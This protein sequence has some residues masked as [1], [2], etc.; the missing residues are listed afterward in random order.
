MSKEK[1]DYKKRIKKFLTFK[2]VLITSVALLFLV[3]Y[4]QIQSVVGTFSFLQGRDSSL[5]TEIGELKESYVSFGEDL[6]EIR[7]FLR[8]PTKNYFDVEEAESEEGKNEEELQIAMFQ[9]VT[10]LSN[11]E[12]LTKKLNDGKIYLTSLVDSIQF[13]GFIMDRELYMSGLSDNES[14]SFISINDLDGVSLV[15]IS[16]DKENGNIYLN[17]FNESQLISASS[18][19]DFESQ[20]K[21]F[22]DD[23]KE[24]LISE[25]KEISKKKQ[26]ILSAITSETTANSLL[27]LGISIANEPVLTSTNYVYSIYNSS[28]EVIGEIVFDTTSLDITLLDKQDESVSVKATDISTALIPFLE[29]LDTRSFLQKKTD[30]ALDKLNKT[31]S[32]KGFKLLLSQAEL[33]ISEEPRETDDRFYFD[34]YNSSE[35]HLSS[36]V[37][38]KAT[39]VVNIVNPDGTNSQNIFFFDSGSKKKTLQLPDVIPDYGDESFSLDNSFNILLAGKHGS[40]VDTMIFAHINEDTRKIRMVSIPRDLYYNGRKIN[41]FAHFYGMPELKK[42]L[43]DITGYEL[44]KFI[45]IDMYAFIDVIDLIGGIDI[46]LDRA[47]IDPTYRVVD[48]GVEGTLHYEPGDY[49]LG[50]VEALRLARTRHTSSDFARAERQ[51]LILKS[52]QDKAKNF[53][54]GDADTIYEIAKTVLN[55]TETDI[56]ID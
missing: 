12:V 21:D 40:L 50:G 13:N 3:Q 39:G 55:K 17:T 54:F 24:S 9:Y 36:I 47:V 2:N 37:I 19:E 41:A 25:G 49:H 8:M 31:L 26:S 15:E 30:E 18:Y 53:G 20:L 28:S 51:Q 16:L 43:S 46:H 45:L 10:Y 6:N 44:D 52:I 32:D 14:K 34:I 1:N 56:S 7:D 33:T 27:T 48:D 4:F 42:V 29:K 23:N 22:V 11:Q 35:T 5:V 38:E